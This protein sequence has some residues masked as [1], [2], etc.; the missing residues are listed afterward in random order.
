M[1]G[2]ICG[3]SAGQECTAPLVGLTLLQTSL[4]VRQLGTQMSWCAGPESS[5]WPTI[6]WPPVRQELPVK[7]TDVPWRVPRGSTSSSSS[8]RRTSSSRGDHQLL[9]SDTRSGRSQSASHVKRQAGR[10][11]FKAIAPHRGPVSCSL[12]AWPGNADTIV[13][14]HVRSL[15]KKGRDTSATD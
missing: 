14:A 8:S 3:G 7:H 5:L 2:A 13:D 15:S 1:C 9:H 6:D 10:E 12:L 4:R 11:N